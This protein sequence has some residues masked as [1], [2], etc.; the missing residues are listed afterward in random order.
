M[1]KKIKKLIQ[2]HFEDGM[3]HKPL[4]DRLLEL[5]EEQ[6]TLERLAGREEGFNDA[7]EPVYEMFKEHPD[8]VKELEDE[9]Y[10]RWLLKKL[11]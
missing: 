2:E 1:E 7:I 3:E 4:V 6:G 9:D 8:W 11:S 5:V 10:K